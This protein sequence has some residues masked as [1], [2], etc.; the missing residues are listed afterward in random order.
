MFWKKS[1]I[2]VKISEKCGFFWKF[3]KKFY[4][5]KFSKK[6]RVW[7]KFTKNIFSWIWKNFDFG[8]IFEHF[9]FDHDFRKK[10]EKIT[11]L[12]KIGENFWKNVDFSQIFKDIWFRSKFTKT[13]FFEKFAKGRFY[14]NFGKLSILVKIYEK[15]WDLG[16]IF[17]KNVDFVSKNFDFCRN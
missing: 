11:I 1:S 15:N 3:R 8:Q 14:S 6:F 9:D 17:W 5:V 7:S 4:F 16:I 2:L 10:I 13:D 12:D